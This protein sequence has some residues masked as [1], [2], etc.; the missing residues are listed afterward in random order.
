MKFPIKPARPAGRLTSWLFGLLMI[1]LAA[2]ALAETVLTINSL[3]DDG[4]AD[5][6]DGTCNTGN[7]WGGLLAECTFRAAIEEANAIDGP[8]RLEIASSISVNASGFSEIEISSSLPAITDRVVID[9]RTH[10]HWDP[11]AELAQPRLVLRWTGPLSPQFSAIRLNAGSA[12]SQVWG[13]AI[14]SFSASGIRIAGG[15]G[16]VIAQNFIGGVWVPGLYLGAGNERHG[17]DLNGGSNVDNPSV[18][19]GNIIAENGEHGIRVRNDFAHGLFAENI[20]GLAP[21]P[22]GG[23][24]DFRSFGGNGSYGIRVEASAGGQNTISPLLSGLGNVI[25]NNGDGGIFVGADNQDIRGNVIGLPINGVPFEFDEL[26][27]YGNGGAGILI[28]SNDNLVGGD[29]DERNIIGNAVTAGIRLGGTLP[30]NNNQVLANRIGISQTGDPVGQ[31][32]GV[33]FSHGSGNVVEG[34]RI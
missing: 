17:I 32:V 28:V 30:A 12:G 23:L 24:D 34:A 15:D 21:G 3:G 26:E 20:I 19:I 16:Y 9:G 4:A 29:G 1:L 2:P 25:A 13:I 7:S 18:I 11:D 6:G 8:F 33:D 5:A 10:P 14:R 31:A 27:D 22:N